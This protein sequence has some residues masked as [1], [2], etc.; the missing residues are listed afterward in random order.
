[1]STA[2]FSPQPAVALHHQVKEDLLLK[3]RAAEWRPGA[4][5]PPEPALCAH[6]GVSRGTLRRAIGDLV[7]EGYLER[8]RGRGTFVSQ[9]KL[10]SGLAGSFGRFT[11]IGPSLDLASRLLGCR[12]ERAQASVAR[13]LKLAAGT[14]VWRLERLRF[15]GGRPATLQTSYLPVELCPGLDRKDLEHRYLLD[16]MSE[17]YGIALAR[18]V[19][20]VD[21][22][23]ADGYMARHLG[24]RR[25]TPLFRVERTTYARED[26]VAEYRLSVLRGDIFRYRNE[27]R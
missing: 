18:A 13:M 17:D 5:I 27:F 2:R 14:P 19:E 16:V 24:I 4:E 22:T 1:M 3:L 10:E 6:Y 12:R 8:Y 9:P 15:T 20:H 21:P 25:G 11:V 26:R 23:V 7:S